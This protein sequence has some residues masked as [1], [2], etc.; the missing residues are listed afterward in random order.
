VPASDLFAALRPDERARLDRF[1]RTFDGLDPLVYENFAP[2]PVDADTVEAARLAA[3]RAIGSGET[4]R[5]AVKA[6][7]QQ[8]V[9]A[10][11]RAI[12]DRREYPSIL[13]TGRFSGPRAA[14]RA[15]VLQSLER[16]VVAVVVWDELTVDER[17]VLLGPWAAIAGRALAE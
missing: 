17:D 7:V 14:D 1:A 9:G 4:R 16:A 3:M 6:A 8:F 10:A 2:A 15:A 13:L 5:D 11:D 12:A